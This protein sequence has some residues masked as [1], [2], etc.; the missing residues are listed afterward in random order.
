[1][2]VFDRFKGELQRNLRKNPTKSIWDI[3]KILFNGTRDT[4]PTNILKSD[5]GLDNRFSR[6]GMYGTGIYF[7]DNSNYSKTYAYQDN[8]SNTSQMFFCFVIVGES[9]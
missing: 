6:E 3:V 1:V 4:N 9:I 8:V 7:A 5:Y 2:Q